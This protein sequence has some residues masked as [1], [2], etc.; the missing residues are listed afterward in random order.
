M[1]L[2]RASYDLYGVLTL[3][4]SP[5]E[6][7]WTRLLTNSVT[8]THRLFFESVG[9]EE[10]LEDFDFTDLHRSVVKISSRS[11]KQEI[12]ALTHSS[13]TIDDTDAAGRTALSWAAQC[14]DA[15][16]MRTLLD[17]GAGPDKATPG[18]K[19][20]LHYTAGVTTSAECTKALLDF[21]AN[22]HARDN[23]GLTPLIWGCI[24]LTGN[25]SNVEALLDCSD[26]ELVDQNGRTALFHAASANVI[27][28]NMLLSK[29]CNVN[30]TDH[31]G[32]T[33]LHLAISY[34]RGKVIRA[35]VENGIDYHC[36]IP[37]SN[38]GILHH[39]A[40]YAE[41]ESVEALLAV[42]LAGLDINAKDNEGCTA[43]ILLE[44]R[45]PKPSPE[46]FEA[47]RRL[48]GQ[49]EAHDA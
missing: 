10:T 42:Q 32:F 26:T 2:Y 28:T 35:L 37:T 16:T 18:S 44:T 5:T 11:V 46:V 19:H 34:N 47:F 27:P 23:V 33:A 6:E 22:V 43:L 24:N 17:Y 13:T 15:E 49:I 7:A 21:G 39:A 36:R 8:P 45:V 1:S 12:K 20:P 3:Y 30:H 25:F 48:L 41:M 40:S 31:D 14:G 29:G 38:Q 9:D 4:R